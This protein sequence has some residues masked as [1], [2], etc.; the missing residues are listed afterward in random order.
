M[1]KVQQKSNLEKAVLIDDGIQ[2]KDSKPLKK[3]YNN[4]KSF[5]FAGCCTVCF[6]VGNYFAAYV[7]SFGIKALYP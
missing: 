3:E 5:M 2:L 1:V 4:L 7:S 6:G